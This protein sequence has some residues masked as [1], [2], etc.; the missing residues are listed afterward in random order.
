MN[1][2]NP[3]RKE[4][5]TSQDGTFSNAYSVQMQKVKDNIPE[6]YEV[7]T[8]S[9]NYM[10]LPNSEVRDAAEEVAR[11]CNIDFQHDKTFFD[12][13]RFAYSMKSNQPVG[14][15][16]EGDDVALGLQ[17][18]NSYDGSKSFGFST[19]LYRLICTNGMLSKANFHTFK[20]NH[21]PSA[22][23]WTESLEK[24]VNNINNLSTGSL[25]LDEI[26]ENFKKLNTTEIT[27]EMLGTIRH[28][29]LTNIPVQ[30]WGSI[31]DRF[32]RPNNDDGNNGWSLLNS[33]TDLLWHKDK[34]TMASYNQNAEIV[35]GLC[36]VVN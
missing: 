34:T 11:E 35:D 29:H 32:T 26:I 25:K 7:G 2:Y 23:N 27:T 18:W 14:E 31:I 30:L 8:V 24:V 17:F 20:F 9:S 6:W 1:P 22:E 33:A 5:L 15:V 21:E 4:S 36:N 16:Q 28:K 10:L 12:G 3:I 13:K 19:M